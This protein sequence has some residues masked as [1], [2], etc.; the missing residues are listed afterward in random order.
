M[1]WRRVVHAGTELTATLQTLLTFATGLTAGGAVVRSL[2]IANDAASARLVKV[3]LIASGGS[4]APSNLIFED[5]VP[6]N[7]TMTP[8]RGPWQGNDGAFVQ[9]ISDTADSDV[10]VRLTCAE[11]VL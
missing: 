3:Y 9:G 1:A 7:T 5:T 4:A 6:A 8:I 10:G 2:S 11:E